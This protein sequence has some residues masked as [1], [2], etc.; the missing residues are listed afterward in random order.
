MLYCSGYV[1]GQTVST[2]DCGGATVVDNS[3]DQLVHDNG[4]IND[5]EHDSDSYERNPYDTE[6][7]NSM[8]TVSAKLLSLRFASS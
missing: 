3:C 4:T 5:T 8:R 7:C 6:D 1:C 2:D